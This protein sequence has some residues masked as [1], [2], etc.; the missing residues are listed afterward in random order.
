MRDEAK[1]KDQLII[2]L[3]ALRQ[4]IAE[5]E[6]D[7]RAS[8]DPAELRHR[9]GAWPKARQTETDQRETNDIERLY[10]ELAAHQI[11]LETQNEELRNALV[12]IE[13]SRRRYSA[14]YDSAPIG[15]LTL[16]GNGLVLEANLTIARQLGIERSRL[17]GRPLSDYIVIAD[18]NAFLSHLGNVLNDRTHQGCEVSFMK[19]SGGDFH[20]LLDTKF[21]MDAVGEERIRTSVTD[22]TKRK[23]REAALRESEERFTRFFRAIPVSTSITRLSDGQ[24]TDINDKFLALFGYTREEV[25]SQNPLKLEMWAGPEERAKMVKI[26]QEQG[27]I[28]DFEAQIHRKSGEIRDVLISAE[29]IEVAGEQYILGHTHDITERKQA[30]EALRLRESYLTAILENQP[31]LVWL[32]DKESR[33]LAVN[34]TFARSCGMERPEEVLGKTDL[35][36]WPRELAEKYRIDDKA[37]LTTGTPI[38]VEEAINDRGEMKWFETFKTPVLNEDGQILG[39]SGYARDITERKNS[40]KALHES[41]LRLRTILQTVNEGFWL[42]DNDTV[43]MDLNPRMCAILGRNREEVFGRKIFDFADSENKAIFEQQIRLRAQGEAGTYE[44]ALSRSDESNVFCLFNSTPLFDGSG[45]K[46]G[47]FA[48]VTDITERVKQDRE[49]EHLN[50]LYSVLSRVSQAVVRATSPEEFLEQACREIVEGGGFLLA[51]IGE[52]ELITNAVVPAALWG[53]MGE[54]L[55]GITVY[56]DNRPEGRGPTGT[57]IRES[58]PSVHN[59]FLNAPQTLP[60]RDRA[61]SFSIASCAAFPIEREG[62]VWGALSVY[63]DEVD[64]FSNEDVKLLEKVADDIG[65]ALDNLDRE[66]RRKRAEDGLRVSLRFLEIVHEHTETAPLLKEYVSEIKNFTGCDAVGI[67]VLDENLNIPYV[68]YQGFSEAFYETESLLSVKSDECMCI[69]VIRGEVNPGLPFFT[70]GGAFCVNAS[71]RFLATV[72]EEEK[73]RTRNRCNMEGYET[74]ALFPFRNGGKILGLIHVADHR[75]N[76]LPPHVVKMLEK[77]ALQLGTAFQRAGA[78]R[79]LRENEAILRQIIDLVPHGIFVK[80]W[81]GKYLLVNKAVADANN[82]SVS[83]LTGRYHADIH[84]DQ[85]ELQKMLR[86]DREVMITGKMKFIPEEP[87]TD[88]KG[89]LRFHQATKVPFHFFGDKTPAVLG[90]A[91]DITE[92]KQAEEE[93]AKMEA[94]LRQALKLE[95]IGTLAGGI[96]HDFNNILQPMM[97]YTE[98]ALNELSPSSPLRD[99]LEQVLNASLR[100]K[101]LVRQILAVSRSTQEQQRI[102]IEISSIIKEALKLLRSTLP[103]SIEIRENIRSGV[104]LADPTQIHQVLMNLCTNAAHAM[105]DK[106]ILGVRLSPVNLSESNWPINQ[107]SISSLAHT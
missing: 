61:A 102:P 63:S 90:I 96:A 67:R 47:S 30:E 75:E 71:S 91:I 107:S 70:E 105:D 2:E 27:R 73:G 81:N 8:T 25:V 48:M 3:K 24:F 20:A 60:W 11:E 100:A 59:D 43:T 68:A 88:A 38:A 66:F 89:N 18:R 98:M 79:K 56:S 29:V 76:M 44:I 78:E 94:E 57:C 31:G 58:R 5:S 106:G 82:T 37:V 23:R 45:N 16:D 9:V 80:D 83:A 54:Y 39:T 32:K 6:K 85:S 101:E 34:Q 7:K 103:T 86:D 51:W 28:Q 35:D 69:N 46:V 53:E 21:I 52:V 84:P 87:Y 33:F 104:A 15:Y 74:V 4:S 64:R 77:A 50:R 93:K 95:A 72:S 17:L 26:L 92:R 55:Q 36:I 65:F 97:G 14:L 40:E 13:E 19:G 42:I 22:I 62:R 12:Q 1:T 10:H 49:I 99:D 41:E